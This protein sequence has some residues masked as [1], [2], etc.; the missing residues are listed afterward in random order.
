MA[1]SANNVPE[2]EIQIEQA[3]ENNECLLLAQFYNS[4]QTSDETET[5]TSDEMEQLSQL[6]RETQPTVEHENEQEEVIISTESFRFSMKRKPRKYRYFKRILREK[7][8]RLP[9]A[10][11]KLREGDF[12]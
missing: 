4:S 9:Q 1:D 3:D 12:V 6:Y 10:A 7:D 2:P 8:T 11:Q 5:Q